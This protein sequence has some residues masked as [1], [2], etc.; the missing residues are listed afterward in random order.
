MTTL[1]QWLSATPLPRNE[2]RLL[3]QHLT[4]YSRAQ[5]IT[6]DHEILSHQQLEQLKAL[7]QRRELGE[8]IAYLLGQREFYGRNFRVSPAVLIPRPETEHLLEAA[9]CR[10]PE[11]GALWDL[12]TGSGI[13]ALSAKLERPDSL[14]FASDFSAAA[15]HI[16]QENAANLGAE[17]AFSQGSWYEAAERFRL[18]ETGLDII[19]S[20]PPYIENNDLHLSQ[21]D[22]RF[23]PQHALTDFA[24]GLAHIRVLIE[25]GKNYL[26]PNA[27]L[28]LE[29]GY[30]QAAAI[31]ALF[32]EHGYQNIETKQDLAGLD[33]I[34][35]GQWRS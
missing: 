18:P 25:Q 21:G 23:E 17:V 32:A 3:L 33:R 4:G 26:K 27:W 16:A 35:F 6:H 11:N 1:S 24:D 9:L 31:R 10:L 7:T 22:L 14:V 8:P 34:T 28:L 30:N 19:V 29:H 2:A 12:G 20:N 15:L 5:L 13:I